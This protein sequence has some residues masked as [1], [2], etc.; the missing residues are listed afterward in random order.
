[1]DK[2]KIGQLVPLAD[3]VGRDAIHVA[4]LPVVAGAMLCPGDDVGV[5]E[6]GRATTAAHAI[7]IVDPFLQ[8][9]VKEGEGF[10]LFVYPGAAEPV[11]HHWTHPLLDAIKPRP[12][13]E[14]TPEPTPVGGEGEYG[15]DPFC[16]GMEG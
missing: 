10:W 12:T 4:V 5:G 3:M 1:M 13:P 2:P 8:E 15:D 14:P 6:D 7:G 16:C 11:R 9:T